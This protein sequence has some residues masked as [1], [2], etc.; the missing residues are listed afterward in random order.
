MVWLK[1]RDCTDQ[2]FAAELAAWEASKPK[3]EAEP[4]AA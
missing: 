4:V 1:M 2:E 3:L